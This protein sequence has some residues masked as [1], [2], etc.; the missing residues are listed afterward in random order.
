MKTVWSSDYL[1]AQMLTLATPMCASVPHSDT[2]RI[3]GASVC[4]LSSEGLICS[5]VCA[6]S[7]LRSKEEADAL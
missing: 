5:Q 4:Y 3:D 6:V 2:V 1:T 7:D